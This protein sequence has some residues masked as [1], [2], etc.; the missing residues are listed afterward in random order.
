MKADGSTACGCWIYSGVFPTPDKNRADERQ[1]H[2]TYGH[3]WGFAWPADRRLLY[4]RASARPDGRPWSER[5]KLIW[6]GAP[7]REW[8]RLDV[9]DFAK[10]K[11]PDYRPPH[12]AVGDAALAGDRPF[13]MHPD[14]VGWIWVP[15]GLA[16]GPLPTHYEPLESPVSNPL[17]PA[18]QI[19]PA[20]MK[21]ERP[22]N[23]YIGA[24]RT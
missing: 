15:T 17:Y 10:T 24:F 1:A 11:A 7:K 2:D 9:P 19:N 5:K 16:D 22:D 4:N 13:I 8:T 21:E 12:D 6:W 23:Q 18:Q 3:G 14:G 20:A